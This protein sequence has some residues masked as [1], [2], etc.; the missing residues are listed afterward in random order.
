MWKLR[1]SHCSQGR[2]HYSAMAANF[3]GFRWRFF[4]SP[5]GLFTPWTMGYGEPTHTLVPWRQGYKHPTRNKCMGW[6]AQI[7]DREVIPRPCKICDWLLN[8]S[9]DHF[10]LRQ[11]KNVRVIME[12]KISKRHILWPTLSTNMVQHVLVDKGKCPWQRNIVIIKF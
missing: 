10:G 6:F 9:Q 4:S 2:G 5:Q 3:S 1:R 12:F 7:M 8:S 11:G